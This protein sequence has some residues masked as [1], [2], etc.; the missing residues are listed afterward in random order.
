[1]AIPAFAYGTPRACPDKR[2][3]R[4]DSLGAAAKAN[5]YRVAQEKPS[6]RNKWLVQFGYTQGWG[7]SIWIWH[8]DKDQP[9]PELGLMVNFGRTVYTVIEIKPF[10]KGLVSSI[11]LC[12]PLEKVIHVGELGQVSN[13]RVMR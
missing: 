13:F 5:R 4:F 9:E 12:R 2:L 8:G 7:R 11:L 10:T 6:K 3:T 1:M